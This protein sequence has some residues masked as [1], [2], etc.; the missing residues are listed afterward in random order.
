M[1]FYQNRIINE[2]AR[3]MTEGEHTNERTNVR[4]YVHT[5]VRDRSYIP[6][7]TLLCEDII[8]TRYVKKYGV[9]RGGGVDKK[10]SLSTVDDNS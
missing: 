6:S 7:T 1:K 10:N 2:V 5:Y 9:R 3:A 8:S 4:M